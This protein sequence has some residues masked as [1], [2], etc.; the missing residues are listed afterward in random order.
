MAPS[1]NGRFRSVGR[2]RNAGCFVS[3]E[4]DKLNESYNA[5]SDTFRERIVLLEILQRKHT[6][7]DPALT[8]QS[9]I[10]TRNPTWQVFLNQISWLCD[11]D[12]G[13]DST[14]SIAVEGTLNGLKYW[15]AANFDKNKKG[16]EHLRKVLGMLSG[17]SA[18]PPDEHKP[19]CDK[20]LKDSIDFSERK[21][22]NYERLLRTAIHFAEESIN[23]E[24]E[25]LGIIAP[26]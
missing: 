18:L 7:L 10:V 22:S 6:P 17:L 9:E 3:S 14:S 20:V 25:S 26:H 16:V 4:C 11:Y 13:G 21:F 5:I 1:V 2:R 19:I 15:L 8:P 23:W 12:K 24:E